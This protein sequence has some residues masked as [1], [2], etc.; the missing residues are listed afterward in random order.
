MSKVVILESA[1]GTRFDGEDSEEHGENTE[2]F[3]GKVKSTIRTLTSDT[4]LFVLKLRQ[5]S[6]PQLHP[7]V[8]F[9]DILFL[10]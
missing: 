3:E 5:N 2:S 10:K 8:G 4:E 9:V 6:S 7:D 1:S